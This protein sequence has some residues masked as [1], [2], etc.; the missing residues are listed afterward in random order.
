MERGAYWVFLFCLFFAPLAFG[1]TKEWASVLMEAAALTSCLLVVFAGRGGSERRQLRAVPGILPLLLFLAYILLQVIP[2]PPAVVGIL[3]PEAS[4]LQIRF[5][6]PGEAPG[7][8]PLSIDPRSTLREFFLW[9]SCAVFYWTSVQLL[10]DAGRLQ[11]TARALAI[12]GGVLSYIALLQYFT[13]G[14]NIYWVFPSHT[15]NSFG[16]YYNRNHYAALIEM[17]LPP[18]LAV[19][20][21]SRPRGAY[22]SW[23]NWIVTV[24]G[25]R[26]GIVHLLLGVSVVLMAVSVFVSLSRGGIVGMC[27][28]TTT[29]AML[30]IHRFRQG[31]GRLVL[32]GVA[33]LV[34]L[35]VTWFGWDPIVRRFEKI[36][37]QEKLLADLRFTY[38]R[39]SVGILRDFTLTGSGL[40]TFTDAYRHYRTLDY[41]SVLTHAHSDYIEFLAD[42]GVVGA[43]LIAGFWVAVLRAVVWRGWRRHDKYSL[44]LVFGCLGGL[45]A[46]A[47]HSFTDFNLRIPANGLYLFFLAGLAVSAAHT[48]LRNGVE[49]ERGAETGAVAGESATF[50]PA[51]ASWGRWPSRVLPVVF[52]LAAARFHGGALLGA[53]YHARIADVSAGRNVSPEARRRYRHAAEKAW[54]FDPLEAQYAFAA[55]NGEMLSGDLDAA[56]RNAMRGL[57]LAPNRGSHLQAAG[58]I[59]DLKG[60]PARAEQL[61]RAGVAADPTNPYRNRKFA[62]WLL[63]RGRTGEGLEYLRQAIAREPERTRDYVALLLLNGVGED[64]IAATLPDRVAAHLRFGDYLRESGR[65]ATAERHLAKA[66]ALLARENKPN[67]GLYAEVAARYEAGKRFEEAL[68]VVLEGC[69]AIPDNAWLHVQAARLHVKLGKPDR[70]AEE[71]RQALRLDSRNDAARRELKALQRLGK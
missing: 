3:S 9:G 19:F 13:A 58:G 44:Y 41:Q 62:S 59:F 27:L 49:A 29:F 2:L 54:A 52:A 7:W 34:L 43:L 18:A 26:A 47:A 63:A 10:A 1:G 21:F 36:A 71:Y 65:G 55:A 37:G 6:A 70:A 40:G 51:A 35:S 57:W 31:R 22:A 67:P 50:L 53:Y 38:W 16:P 39:D 60:D 48:R 45:V 15:D 24:W 5:L 17:I 56:V 12:F 30:L 32:T 4:R 28:G 42:M 23:R 69:A 46:I 68:G 33:A 66:A 20:L 25:R 8:L 61:M 11:R 14:N 64:T